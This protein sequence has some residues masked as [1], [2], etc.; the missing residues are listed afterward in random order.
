MRWIDWKNIVENKEKQEMN[1]RSMDLYPQ[2]L[3]S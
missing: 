1:S 2:S 3:D